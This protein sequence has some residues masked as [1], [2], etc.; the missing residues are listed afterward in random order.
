MRRNA[1]IAKE[2]GVPVS[3]TGKNGD[4]FVIAPTP[5]LTKNFCRVGRIAINKTHERN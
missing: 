5:K 4:L 2:T 1:Q 3:M